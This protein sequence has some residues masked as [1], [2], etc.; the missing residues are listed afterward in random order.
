MTVSELYAFKDKTVVKATAMNQVLSNLDDQ[1][2]KEVQILQLAG[3]VKLENLLELIDSKLEGYP[4]S[5]NS[6]E[7]DNEFSSSVVQ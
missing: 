6:V 3:N 5:V 7:K 1:L 2:R 4:F